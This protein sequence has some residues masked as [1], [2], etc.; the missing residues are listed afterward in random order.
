MFDTWFTSTLLPLAALGWPHDRKSSSHL[1][2]SRL[3][4]TNLLETGFDIMYFWAFRMVGMCYTLSS[5]VPFKEIMFHG[6]IRDSLGRKM[7]KSIGN[8]IDPIDLID[9]VSAKQMEERVINAPGL[10]DKE[11]YEA[12]KSQ[13]KMWPNGIE[14][15]GSDA[16]RLALLVQDFKCM[17]EYL[18]NMF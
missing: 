5:S 8:V 10:S 17:T 9:G 18:C 15:V 1:P 6:L 11:K 16:M 2:L 12:T 4:P 7:S 14:Q 3:Y 13:K